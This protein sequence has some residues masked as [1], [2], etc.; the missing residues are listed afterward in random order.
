MTVTYNTIVKCTSCDEKAIK[1]YVRQIFDIIAGEAV[2]AINFPFVSSI[3]MDNNQ[4]PHVIPDLAHPFIRYPLSAFEYEVLHNKD[5]P[6]LGVMPKSSWEQLYPN[7]S[8]QEKLERQQTIR[9]AI[10]RRANTPN[11]PPKTEW[12]DEFAD[13]EQD[14]ILTIIINK[15][16]EQS[17]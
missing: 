13:I 8:D 10:D 1:Q 7:A 15:Q 17:I 16:H 6:P 3:A 9:R 5:K 11:H 4:V 2:V 14:L 12:F